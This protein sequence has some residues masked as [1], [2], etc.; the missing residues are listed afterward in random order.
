MS[1]RV[2]SVS[3]ISG[4]A[5]HLGGLGVWGQLFGVVLKQ[6]QKGH[7]PPFFHSRSLSMGLRGRKVNFLK[8]NCL[9]RLPVLQMDE[10]VPGMGARCLHVWSGQ[11]RATAN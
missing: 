2:R 7:Q 4:E 1:D 9:P 10:L 5:G 6:H 11:T 3:G 8:D